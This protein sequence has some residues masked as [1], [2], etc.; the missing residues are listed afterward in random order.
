M[1]RQVDREGLEAV[2]LL[3]NAVDKLQGKVQRLVTELGDLLADDEDMCDLYLKRRGE[4]EGLAPVPQ[5]W[6]M[7]PGH[8]ESDFEAEE[9]EQGEG[10]ERERRRRRWKRRRGGAGTRSEPVLSS[11]GRRRGHHRSKQKQ[12]EHE[13]QATIENLRKS[14]QERRNT[15]RGLTHKA[16]EISMEGRVASSV[17]DALSDDDSDLAEEALEREEEEM[18]QRHASMSLDDG[19]VRVHPHEIEEAED[20]LETMFERADMLLRRL[21][22]LDERTNDTEDLL[23]LE[24]DQKRNQLVGLNLLVSSVSMAFGFAAAVGGIFG[25]NLKNEELASAGWVLALVL[26]LMGLGALLLVGFVVWY[27][28]KRKLMFIPTTL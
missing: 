11:P 28:R 26:V 23:E 16:S 6:E 24:L 8:T 15:P 2:R 13:G 10:A 12:K 22:L 25:M 27:V 3:K 4:R 14:R 18:L 9:D 21:T 5:P 19:V 17:D 20:L 7:M 1:L